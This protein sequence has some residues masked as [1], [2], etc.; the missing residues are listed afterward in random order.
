MV[1]RQA[2]GEKT[3][4]NRLDFSV[5]CQD[6]L[7][8]PPEIKYP[9]VKIKGKI[10]PEGQA[11]AR[12]VAKVISGFLFE[13]CWRADNER[14]ERREACR[15]VIYQG[16][17]IMLSKQLEPYVIGSSA[18]AFDPPLMK[19]I[20]DVFGGVSQLL[21]VYHQDP[22]PLRQREAAQLRKPARD[23]CEDLFTRMLPKN[24][25]LRH[26]FT[27]LSRRLQDWLV[28]RVFNPHVLTELLC[29]I[30]LD[31]KPDSSEMSGKVE[32]MK[33]GFPELCQQIGK[34]ALDCLQVLHEPAR[35]QEMQA[36]DKEW[37]KT[38]S[39]G[40]AGQKFVG[41]FKHGIDTIRVG[42]KTAIENKAID[43]LR[44]QEDTV[45]AFILIMVKDALEGES[46]VVPLL[47]SLIQNKAGGVD[48]ASQDTYTQEYF[49]LEPLVRE[50][51]RQ[52]TAL[53]VE[54]SDLIRELA[55]VENAKFEPS[56]SKVN[57]DATEG[58]GRVIEEEI[59]KQEQAAKLERL[60]V[61]KRQ[62]EDKHKVLEQKSRPVLEQL[63][64]LERK[65]RARLEK[66]LKE[67]VNAAIQGLVT[68]VPIFEDGVKKHVGDLFNVVAPVLVN[69]LWDD[70]RLAESIVFNVAA[71]G[72]NDYFFPQGR[73]A[74]GEPKLSTEKAKK[75]GTFAERLAGDYLYTCPREDL[76]VD[77]Y[78][79]D[80][81]RSMFLKFLGASAERMVDGM[82]PKLE[83]TGAAPSKQKQVDPNLEAQRQAEFAAMLHLFLEDWHR[84]ELDRTKEPKQDLLNF[85]AELIRHW[86]PDD[87]AFQGR[88][89]A[90]AMQAVDAFHKHFLTKEM[91]VNI[92]T[93]YR[94]P[95]PKEGD[96]EQEPEQTQGESDVHVALT[97]ELEVCLDTEI[98]R[99]TGK[100][101]TR[102]A[103]SAAR[104]MNDW[105]LLSPLTTVSIWA[106]NK[107]N[108]SFGE[109]I[110]SAPASGKDSLDAAYQ[111]FWF[112]GEDR[113]GQVRFSNQ[114]WTVGADKLDEKVLAWFREQPL[115]V[116]K[117]TIDSQTANSWWITRVVT[118]PATK[119]VK[120]KA[121][122]TADAVAL[123]VNKLLAD[124]FAMQAL[125]YRYLLPLMKQQ[126][127]DSVLGK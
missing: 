42:G 58:I 64:T 15:N 1:S 92:F 106:L 38:K 51:E 9:E 16:M 48:T 46:A 103:R 119:V 93:N 95:S 8:H 5:S 90:L 62:L 60:K 115:K 25:E 13:I 101:F 125:L 12:R 20:A 28:D 72:L 102:T 79:D 2:S 68:S 73:P 14:G 113:R 24:E 87:E 118:W 23:L 84:G 124:E 29:S 59:W 114:N 43:M 30:K 22:A 117:K 27:D 44:K 109:L 83:E 54:Q 31:L 69:M 19:L 81:F 98:A 110:L 56:P 120:W 89:T 111:V 47:E 96:V 3:P 21:M 63:A 26:V 35:K 65:Q 57:Q 67:D 61:A 100:E 34:S 116:V 71:K 75:W 78:S 39:D 107:Y 6:L 85:V 40:N 33:K 50:I 104:S 112:T 55:R 53:R 127:V 37:Q 108:G 45:G 77:V 7:R 86:V 32:S 121:A 105:G 18:V 41:F 91:L 74:A 36:V 11:R 82:T 76:R 97:K 123:M 66:L 10:S 49:R 80:A 17:D 99:A 88:C 52:Q 70:S 94:L 4:L 126:I 122:S